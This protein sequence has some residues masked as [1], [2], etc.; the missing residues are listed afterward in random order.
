MARTDDDS[1]IW[2]IVANP[3]PSIEKR[4]EHQIDAPLQP[5]LHGAAV[6][7]VERAAV[8]H[9]VQRDAK[10]LREHAER[11]GVDFGDNADAELDGGLVP[12]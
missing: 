1:G 7:V 10:L 9:L 2:R 4:F 11:V 6:R 12:T 3:K 5:G 8:Q